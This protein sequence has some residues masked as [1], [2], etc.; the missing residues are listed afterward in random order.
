[1]ILRLG[2]NIMITRHDKY[3]EILII[4][5]FETKKTK[6]KLQIFQQSNKIKL[7]LFVCTTTAQVDLKMN[8]NVV[9][10]TAKPPTTYGK[11]SRATC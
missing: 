4:I 5:T 3:F 6:K 10:F 8:T 9:N 7:K 11:E 2:N 1:M